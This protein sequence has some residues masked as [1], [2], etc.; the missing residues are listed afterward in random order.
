[1]LEAG[2]DLDEV[3]R[4]ARHAAE[5][6]ALSLG[7][8][9][10]NYLLAA[11]T[12]H[13][14]IRARGRTAEAT[15]LASELLRLASERGHSD[16]QVLAALHQTLGECHLD[17]GDVEAAASELGDAW[18]IAEEGAAY[19]SDPYHPRRL[20]LIAALARVD[21]ARGRVA[22]A[23]AWRAQLPEPGK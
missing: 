13:S 4:V 2:S 15:V 23:A 3:E 12:L 17:A 8:D 6:L 19:A 18:R 7:P 21:E 14:V 9:D 20:A 5:K 11:D 22:E 16:P 1:M 10:L